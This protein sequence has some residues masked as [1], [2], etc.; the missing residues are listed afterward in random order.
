MADVVV[1]GLVGGTH[2]LEDIGIDI[3][4]G[5]TVVMP[6]AKAAMS[7]DLYRAINQKRILLIPRADGQP[8][9]LRTP[10]V[11]DDILQQRCQFLELRNKQLEDEN[12][13]LRDALQLALRQQQQLDTIVAAL[14]QLKVAPVTTSGVGSVSSELADG[15]APTFIPENIRPKDAS[16]RIDVVKKETDGADISGA[17]GALRRM[18]SGK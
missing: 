13:Q 10:Q 18:R 1:Y 16:S 14:G 6:A 3:R 9:P 17:V 8:H 2:V 15:S 7:K 5:V 4:Q 11:H 12:M